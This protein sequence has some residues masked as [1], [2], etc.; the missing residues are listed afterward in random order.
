MAVDDDL[1]VALAR[2]TAT[3]ARLAAIEAR[4]AG[5]APA[6]SSG[7]SSSRGGEVASDRDLSGT[8]GDP[9]VKKNPPRW[10]G[11]SWAGFKYSE[12]PSDFL[13]EMAS[14]HDWRADQAEQKSETYKNKKGQD[15]P[16]APLR[17]KDAAIARGWA[18]RNQGRTFAQAP[19]AEDAAHGADEIPF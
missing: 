14:F 9:E 19:A 10:E 1:R 17:R 7:S 5:G 6:P 4:L 18:R 11:Q 15:V 16:T 12:C 13:E 2:I 3:E 8:Y